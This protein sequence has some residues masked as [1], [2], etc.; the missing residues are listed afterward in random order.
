MNKRRVRSVRVATRVTWVVLSKV[1]LLVGVT[2][3]LFA[4][5]YSVWQPCRSNPARCAPLDCDIDSDG[6][7]VPDNEEIVP[8]FDGYVTEPG[9]SDSDFD[10]LEDNEDW[11]PLDA[12]DSSQMT[13]PKPPRRCPSGRPVGRPYDRDSDGIA[14]RDEGHGIYEGTSPNQAD[15]D[16]DGTPDAID[17]CPGSS[18]EGEA[19]P[20]HPHETEDRCISGRAKSLIWYERTGLPEKYVCWGHNLV[21]GRVVA[22]DGSQILP[23]VWAAL[24]ETSL[25]VIGSFGL[26]ALF[27]SILISLSHIFRKRRVA[28]SLLDLLLSATSVPV[29][30]V[31][32]LAGALF[33]S[34]D[35]QVFGV[36][37]RAL[38]TQCL[39]DNHHFSMARILSSGVCLKDY[40]QHLFIP[41]SVLALGDG[42]IGYFVRKTTESLKNIDRSSY[43]Q[44]ARIRGVARV[45]LIIRYFI[46]NIAVP[47]LIF[48]RERAIFLVSGAVVVEQIY[49]RRGLGSLLI[50]AVNE[51]NDLPLLMVS[52]TCLFI[53]AFVIQMAARAL[54]VLIDRRLLS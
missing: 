7:G 20:D 32:F 52:A 4:G 45:R 19:I 47:S 34:A 16:G 42:N 51:Y 17:V 23:T 28:T 13:S 29:V 43:V 24:Q 53:L 49:S 50:E 3:G 6:D 5:A 8:G 26:S 25:L 38:L 41:A 35:F 2:F 33:N 22:T 40:M 18:R 46:P 54:C 37:D 1:F 14:D 30:L 48:A 11:C 44:Y 10:G 15:S 36:V 21:L 12:D 9:L 31:G 39:G 27:A